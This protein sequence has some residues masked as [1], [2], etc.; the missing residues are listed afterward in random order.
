M[1]VVGLPYPNIHSAEWK[2]KIEHVERSTY[3]RA[4]GSSNIT[5]SLEL[6]AR[7]EAKA[8]GRDFYENACMRAVNQSIGRAIRHRND[9]A[10]IILL[11]KRYT[12]ERVKGKLP[13]WIQKGLV[14]DGGSKPFS[15]VMGS[16]SGFFRSK[17]IIALK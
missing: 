11:D 1:V 4:M 16:L 6:A 12:N 3:E 14:R 17:K 10:C 5:G 9:Y 8:A 15:A 2:A 13:G 7:T